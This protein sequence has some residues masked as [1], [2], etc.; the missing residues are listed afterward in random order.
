MRGVQPEETLG[1]RYTGA[2]LG[3]AA[4][5]ALG[6]TVEFKPRGTFE[7]LTDIVGGGPFHLP[8]G[9]WTDDTSMALCLAESLV[10]CG[11]FDVRDQIERYC[12]WYER[13][14]WSSTGRCFDIGNTT[15][16]ALERY[17]AT[18]DLLAGSTDPG[19]AG[20]GCI[21]RLAPVPLFFH[22]DVGVAIEHAG[23]SALTTHGAPEC[24]ESARLL[25]ALL[26]RALDTTIKE[27]VLGGAQSL[28]FDSARLQAIA[29]GAYVDRDARDIRGS[30]YVV[31]CLE[32]A[33]WCF[34]R[35]ESFTDA[36]LAAA[37]LGDDADTTAAVC[38]QLAGAFYGERGIPG[39]WIKR[40]VRADDIRR[41]AL[42]LMT[43]E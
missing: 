4:G 13:G 15:R 6:T 23:R 1:D 24:V 17:R 43:R 8:P 39:L 12:A 10:E 29:R 16:A 11:G 36:V 37:N 22:A 21:M 35:T 32:A 26:V 27:D 5:D 31:D 40:L 30:G 3:L 38:G 2:L 33:L 42:R 7:P 28:V 14:H 41:L 34:A 19:S 25:G 20:N 9:Y 18:G